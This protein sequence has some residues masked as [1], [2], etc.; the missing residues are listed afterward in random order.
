MTSNKNFSP[1]LSAYLVYLLLI[2]L[3]S[4]FGGF[5]SLLINMGHLE[6]ST[7]RGYSTLQCSNAVIHGAEALFGVLLVILVINSFKTRR[8]RHQ[9]PIFFVLT[10]T[11]LSVIVS[12]G[13]LLIV[14]HRS[15][16]PID[17]MDEYF[18]L[19]TYTPIVVFFFVICN[20]F[21]YK[22]LMDYKEN[23]K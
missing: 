13:I 6:S 22:F 19:F 20:V 14:I 16:S 18:I 2:G 1:E 5:L 12:I 3:M 21:G 4:L 7:N 8:I 11:F 23:S 15:L 9:L 17:P 10:G